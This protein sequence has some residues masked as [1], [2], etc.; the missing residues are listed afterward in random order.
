MLGEMP[1]IP[2]LAYLKLFCLFAWEFL[3]RGMKRPPG[4]G[5]LKIIR[6]Q[7]LL[8]LFGLLV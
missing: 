2:I 4:E 1:L 3:N 7:L 8:E 6:L 5:G